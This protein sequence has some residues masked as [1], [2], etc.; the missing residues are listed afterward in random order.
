MSTRPFLLPRFSGDGPHANEE[1]RNRFRPHLLSELE[2][3]CQPP[4]EFGLVGLAVEDAEWSTY[5]QTAFIALVRPAQPA[6]NASAMAWNIYQEDRNNFEKQLSATALAVGTIVDS[7][8]P[9][10]LALIVNPDTSRYSSNLRVILSSLDAQYRAITRQEL[11]QARS[12]LATR[13]NRTSDFKTHLTVHRQTHATYVAAKQ[14]LSEN[15]KV[16]FLVES[17]EHDPEANAAILH[18]FN[19]VPDMTNQKFDDLAKAIQA[20]LANR[21]NSSVSEFAGATA[22]Y[23]SSSDMHAQID[24]LTRQVAHLSRIVAEGIPNRQVSTT[25]RYCWTHGPNSSHEGK[26]CKTPAK[27]HRTD[28]TFSNRMGGA[29]KWDRRAKK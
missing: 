28:A 9:T 6:A 7:L 26:D 19:T 8:G 2:R 13:Y 12:T 16:T 21:S 20:N 10:A 27:E 1:Y 17:M 23:K 5:S 18:Y 29:D 24:E 14:H 15:D 11:Q 4:H 22:P 25:K 3:H